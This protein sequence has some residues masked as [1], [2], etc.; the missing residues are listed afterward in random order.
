MTVQS[1]IES[2]VRSEFSPSHMEIENESHKHH[3]GLGA[4]SHFRLLLVSEG[5]EGLNRLSRQRKV[6]DVLKTEM[7]LVHA[8]SLRLL[9]PQE[10]EKGQGEGFQSPNC[11]GG[12]KH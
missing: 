12:H 4:E 10:W 1:V 2:K 3:S 11:A 9:T 8:L 7:E 5:F 6:F